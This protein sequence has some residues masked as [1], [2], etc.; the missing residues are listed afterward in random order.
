MRPPLFLIYLASAP[1]LFAAIAL[2]MSEHPTVEREEYDAQVGLVHDHG[3]AG[4]ATGLQGMPAEILEVSHETSLPHDSNHPTCPCRHRTLLEFLVDELCPPRW[5]RI[6]L[7][8]LFVIYWTPFIID[9]WLDNVAL[10]A[11]RIRNI[12]RA[13]YTRT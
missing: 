12:H 1:L 2:A 11:F 8:T 6:T 9:Q 3:G 10:V 5:V 13:V 4:D 7:A